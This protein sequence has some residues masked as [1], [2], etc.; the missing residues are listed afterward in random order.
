MGTWTMSILG[1]DIDMVLHAKQ[2]KVWLAIKLH[3]VLPN[4][5]D[6]SLHAR[7]LLKTELLLRFSVLPR[8]GWLQSSEYLIMFS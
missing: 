6:E 2:C 5:A 1:I 4:V 3:Q 8:V 7:R